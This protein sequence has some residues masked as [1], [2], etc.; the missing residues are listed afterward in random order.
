MRLPAFAIIAISAL[1]LCVAFEPASAEEKGVTDIQSMLAE[2]G[3]N[4]GPVD[5]LWGKRTAR[6]AAAY[7][8]AHGGTPIQ[9]NRIEL[10]AQVDLHRVGDAGPCPAP[11]GKDASTKAGG[12]VEAR[13][14]SSLVDKAKEGRLSKR[15]AADK[16]IKQIGAELDR[17]TGTKW[18]KSEGYTIEVKVS[19]ETVRY[20]ETIEWRSSGLAYSIESEISLSDVVSAEAKA[21][22]IT[23]MCRSGDG[24]MKRTIV[25]FQE[26]SRRTVSMNQGLM[27]SN[28]PAKFNLDID[29]NKVANLIN[30]LVISY[31]GV[32][33]S[34]TTPQCFEWA[35][36]GTIT[37]GRWRNS[38]GIS[39]IEMS[40][41]DRGKAYSNE[42]LV[43]NYNN[44]RQHCRVSGEA[45]MRSAISGMV[46]V[47]RDAVDF[48][49]EKTRIRDFFQEN[50]RECERIFKRRFD[51]YKGK[52]CE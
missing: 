23:L 36:L 37:L 52:I 28:S 26:G 44:S 35:D 39:T 20:T 29:F 22:F 5:G 12:P 21:D 48:R 8:R 51:K 47:G 41:G 46:V 31:Q 15:D 33:K 24:C 17:K 34:S 45:S 50:V 4:P 43:K 14:D 13:S 16:L 40:A 38:N 25:H 30:E 32:S 11:S 6:A 10:I 7:V 18:V 42:E 9:D 27:I 3:F 1:A 19:E 2:C 49:N